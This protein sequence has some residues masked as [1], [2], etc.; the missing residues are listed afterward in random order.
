MTII[1]WTL[2]IAAWLFAA[3]FPG[4]RSAS[5]PGRAP[6]AT[7]RKAHPE[8]EPPVRMEALLR[9]LAKTWLVLTVCSA[10]ALLLPGA[11]A[12]LIFSVIGMPI[13]YLLL[14]A[15]GIWLYLTPAL[16]LYALL[17]WAFGGRW[18]AACLALAVLP[19][20]ALGFLVP[21]LANRETDARVARLMSDD[22][23][24]PPKVPRGRAITYATDRGLGSPGVC[25]DLCQR[26]LFSRT[27]SSFVELPLDELHAI[28]RLPTATRKFS[29]GPIDEACANAR[30]R[31]TFASDEEA[32][33]RRPPPLLWEALEPQGLCLHDD[34]VQDATADLLVVNRWNYDPQFRAFRFE[35]TGLRLSLHPIEPFRRREVFTRRPTGWA[36]LLRRTEVRYAHLASP[37]WLTPGLSF[38]TS[39][40]THWS[41]THHR[42]AGDPVKVYHATQWDGII[43][44]DLKVDGLR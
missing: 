29:L 40:P 11:P 39:S 35:G 27:A 10:C 12:F 22:H 20:M 37:L 17:H 19:P 16:A 3:L 18:T 43:A 6:R 33:P 14:V 4:L 25:G 5:L 30:L 24:T 7:T 2:G 26:L 41:W 34:P 28:A 1:W 38:D 31:A 36:R 9:I 32:G 13:A 44:N 8:P 21:W 15:P 42:S 23:G